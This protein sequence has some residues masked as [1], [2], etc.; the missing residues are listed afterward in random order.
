[1]PFG[2]LLGSTF[3][4]VFETQMEKLQDGDRFYY[5]TR[6]AGLNF[7]TQL[8]ESSFAELVMRN[9]DTKHLPFD[10]FSTPD[11]TFELGN[12]GTEGAV[13]DDEDTPYN[14]SE[15]LSRTPN[16]TVRFT[17]G[18]H[19]VLGGTDGGDDMRADDGDDT[20]WG[21]GGHDKLEG[22]A[23]NDALNG[24]AGDDIISDVFGDDNIK[25]G[26]GHDAINAGG[27]F[28]LILS[29]FGD[30]FVIAGA[31]PKETFAGGGDDLVNGGDSSDTVF[32]NEGDDWIEGGAQADL[33]QG[34][35]GEPFQDDKITGDDVIIGQ[36]GNDDYDS[37]GG[38]DIM[39]TGP[40]IERNEG[41]LGFDWVTHKGDPQAA[42]ADMDFTGLQPPD[43][44]NVRDRFDQVEGLSGWKDND[45]LRADSADAA[46]MV[47][48]ELAGAEAIR[49]IDGLSNLLGA[50]ATGF[51]G[52]NIVLGGA[53]SDL[54]EGRGGNDVIDGDAWLDVELEAPDGE[55]GTRRVDEMADLQA[56]VF[57]GRLNPT[58]IRIVREIKTVAEPGPQD[59]D[60][61]EYSGNLEDYDL[62]PG[63]GGK[64]TVVH[65]RGTLIDG[66]DTLTNVERLK[67]A[68]QT[69]EV[70]DVPSNTPATGTVGI[71]DPTPIEDQPLTATADVADLDGV[72]RSTLQFSWQVEERPDVWTTVGSGATFTP[73]DA[74]VGARLRVVASFADHDRVLETVTSAPTAAVA[75]V[76]D[77]PAGAPLLD[78]RTPQ[79]GRRITVSTGSI[80]DPDGLAAATFARQWQR[81]EGTSWTNIGG[82][83]GVTFTPGPADVGRRLRVLVTFTDDNGTVE[84]LLSAETVQV[85]AAP[86][87]PLSGEPPVAGTASAGPVQA[88]APTVPGQPAAPLA[89]R[90]VAVPRGL[91]ADAVASGLSVRFTAPARTQVVRIRLVRAGSERVLARVF[92]KARGGKATVELRQRRI[93]RALSRGGRFRLRLTPGISRAKLGTTT[94]KTFTVRR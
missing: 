70:V 77:A 60:T 45:I 69:I 19:I 73:Q 87:A 16:G 14:E 92:V 62:E 91:S 4:Y 17:G 32:G 18:E 59:V 78:D 66:T 89:L 25:G 9:T 46:A 84:R 65:A 52:G 81:G 68:D 29:G 20:L 90:R 21:D 28:D 67:F 15:L 36:G 26:D 38:N 75:N 37:E 33:L 6:T 72:D 57:A 71:S 41:M 56:D 58:D 2:G 85:T 13:E 76:N 55:G 48:N 63:A 12:V 47:D 94:V 10:V 80:T 44:D 39:V 61:A 53:G 42:N 79:E 31:D 88:D 64:L 35:N 50:D 54:I 49:R 43:E 24:N 11:Y 93:T 83:T 23:G 82:A 74:E 7:L 30:D 22:G 86:S 40:G 5:L 1:M 8:E 51:T 27:G 3:N 34:G